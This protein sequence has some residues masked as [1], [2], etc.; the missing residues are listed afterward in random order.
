VIRHCALFLPGSIMLAAP[1][2]AGLIEAL[3]GDVDARA[4][5]LELYATPSPPSDYSL[6]LE[7]EGLVRAADEAGFE[8]FHLG[9]YSGGGASCLAFATRHPERLLSLALMEPAFAGWGAMTPEEQGVWEA[10]RALLDSEGP[11]TMAR[12]QGLQLAPGVTPSP[13]PPGPPPAWM[14]QRPAGV[15]ALLHAFFAGDLDLA[16][17][18]QFERPVWFAL[19]GRSN[20]DYFGREAGRLAATFRDFTLEVFPER[21]HFD[22]PHRVEPARVAASLRALWDRAEPGPNA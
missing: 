21:H 9:G 12:F 8:Q 17:L 6:E 4:K 3:G 18:R 13:P 20:P 5:D 16:A 22:P 14:A 19:G 11:E 10:F 2:Y 1:A 15:Q 7:V